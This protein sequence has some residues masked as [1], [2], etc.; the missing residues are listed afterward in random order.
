MRSRNRIIFLGIFTALLLSG[1][2][3]AVPGAE[4]EGGDDRLIGAFITSDHLDLFDMDA[5]LQDHA[6]WL[7]KANEIQISNT[8][9]YEGRLY[10]V[11]DKKG[12][13]DTYDWDISFKDVEGIS[14]FAPVLEDKDG[15]RGWHS[16][17]DA[18]ISDVD[19]NITVTDAGDEVSLEG[20]IYMIPGQSDKGISYYL[21]P[22]Y[23]TAEGQVYLIAGEGFSTSG[24]SEEEEV[25]F[26][27]ALTAETKTTENG[28]S[29]TAKSSVKVSFATMHRPVKITLYKMDEA[30]QCI[31]QEEYTPGRLPES[32]NME[33]GT[34]YLLAETEKEKLSGERFSDR[35]V[36]DRTDDQ[37]DKLETWYDCGNGILAKQ[38][39]ALVWEQ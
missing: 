5:Y 29:Q 31:K 27:S 19:F 8:S 15:N 14:F 2:S 17:Y 7:V 21:N 30:H 4:T 12:S 11:I 36:Y 18:G 37:E 3:L 26:A 10:A 20:T 13:E 32:L 1:C 33:P 9:G 28:K 24:E 35:A 39:S 38:E 16:V 25:H 22:V 34:A 6:S 23:Q